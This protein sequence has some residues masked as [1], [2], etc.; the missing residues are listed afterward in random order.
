MDFFN[1][2]GK[3]VSDMGKIGG[4]KSL[5]YDEK[6]KVDSLY[7]ELGTLYYERNKFTKN[8]LFSAQIM[9]IR[10]SLAKI[11]SYNNQIAM[12]K[13]GRVCAKCGSPMTENDLFCA[14]CGNRVAPAS[15]PAQAKQCKNCGTVT[16]GAGAFCL[17]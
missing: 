6:K 2:I 8:P 12:L 4:L 16:Q 13:S 3:S 10:D 1:D 17:P 11:D 7:K 14:T 5:I 9:A 15:A